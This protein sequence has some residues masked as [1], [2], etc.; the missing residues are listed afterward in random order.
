MENSSK[1]LLPKNP[2]ASRVAHGQSDFVIFIWNNVRYWVRYLACKQSISECTESIWMSAGIKDSAVVTPWTTI[3]W[4]KNEV[5]SFCMW[6]SRVRVSRHWRR[7]GSWPPGRAQHSFFLAVITISAFRKWV[8]GRCACRARKWRASLLLLPIGTNVVTWLR[9]RAEGLGQPRAPLFFEHSGR[10]GESL[11]IWA[12]AVPISQYRTH[13]LHPQRDKQNPSINAPPESPWSL[14]NA[15]S[16]PAG[17]G[18]VPHGLATCELKGKWSA[19]CTHS[20]TP[21]PMVKQ[22]VEDHD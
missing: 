12:R 5:C 21:C 15:P 1:L 10:R 11:A 13:S 14:G 18:V 6:Q 17:L 19:L 8:S 20:C 22:G 4:L 2:C 3:M 9:H 16:F 7:R